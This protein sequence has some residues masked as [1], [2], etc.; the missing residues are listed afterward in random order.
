MQREQP[1]HDDDDDENSLCNPLDSYALLQSKHPQCHDAYITTMGWML[2]CIKKCHTTQY[3]DVQIL[4]TP[5]KV[6]IQW[7]LTI[8]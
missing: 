6:A 2:D 3:V 8:C 7:I 1:L 4:P 5:G